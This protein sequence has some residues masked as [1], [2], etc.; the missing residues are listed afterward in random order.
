M[1]FKELSLRQANLRLTTLRSKVRTRYNILKRIAG[2]LENSEQ[3]S[4]FLKQVNDI[5]IDTSYLNSI[6]GDPLTLSLDQFTAYGEYVEDKLEQ[7]NSIQEPQIERPITIRIAKQRS[8][9]RVRKI[10]TRKRPEI[11]MLEVKMNIVNGIQDGI[12]TGK[13]LRDKFDIS[14]HYF[15]QAMEQLKRKN[16]IGSTGSTRNL[17]F[18][19]VGTEEKEPTVEMKENTDYQSLSSSPETDSLIIQNG[20]QTEELVIETQK[21]DIEILTDTPEEI[22]YNTDFILFPS[23]QKLDF[24]KRN[25]HENYSNIF[26]ECGDEQKHNLNELLSGIL[27]AD[28]LTAHSETTKAFYNYFNKA[29]A[30]LR[31]QRK[32]KRF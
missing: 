5:E 14:I 1:S 19:I 32:I 23:S 21:A 16:V 8:P 26:N 11:D 12:V 15:N 13:A 6:R 18:Y 24:I 27:E 7:L 9:K 3:Y 30:A 4:D 29:K 2:E 22:L 20:Q 10:P 17:Q 28:Q 25:A 31:R